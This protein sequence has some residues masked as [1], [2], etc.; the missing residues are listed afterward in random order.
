MT[1][2]TRIGFIGLGIMGSP[3]SVHLATAGHQVTGFDRD[4]ARRPSRSSRPVA[5]TQRR[6]RRP[7]RTLT[8]SA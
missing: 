3:M 5:R 2:A 4:A 6:R 7:S 8:S 1:S